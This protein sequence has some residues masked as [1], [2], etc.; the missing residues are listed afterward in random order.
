MTEETIKFSSYDGYKLEGTMQR[1][2]KEKAALLFVHGITS[3]R[4]EL[5]FHSDY[6]NY[7][8]E[9]GVSSFRFDYRFHGV[10]ETTLEELTLSGIVNDVSAA[11]TALA[12]GVKRSTKRFFLVGTSF[13]GGLAAYWVDTT[14][15][16]QIRKVI[17][18][19]PVLNYQ[20]DVLER[21]KL[22]TEKGLTPAAVRQLDKHG[23]LKSSGIRFGRAL[24]NELPYVNG[25]QALSNLGSRVVIFHGSDDE[26]VPLTSSKK[27]KSPKTRLE[28]IK[29]VGH[30]F[31]IEID[32]DLNHPE[33]KLIHRGIYKTALGIIEESL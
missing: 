31:G 8:A 13:G 17:L 14:R 10:H 30:G 9:N 22:V 5:G 33:T 28:I 11:Y 1:A 15:Q 20:N 24:I 3:S 21:N 4:D 7:L 12:E 27:H 6:A 2:A 25:I 32:E 29:G 19:A 26:D 16:E 23:F 18:N